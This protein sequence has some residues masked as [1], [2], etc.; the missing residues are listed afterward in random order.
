M[1]TYTFR[2]WYEA[3]NPRGWH[4]FRVRAAYRELGWKYFGFKPWQMLKSSGFIPE[5]WY[6]LKCRLWKKYN[7]VKVRSLPPTWVDR[8]QLLLHAAFEILR[9]VVENEN[10]LDQT[11]YFIPI[12]ES[13]P[14]GC[15]NRNGWQAVAQLYD[16]WINRRP[17]RLA[18]EESALEHWYGTHVSDLSDERLPRLQLFRE[19]EEAGDREDE[20]ML[21][22][23]C[24]IRQILWT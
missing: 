10:W 17:A 1:K 9:D 22:T 4:L 23:L 5:L 21:V 11:A 8:D 24:R 14:Y 7:V 13:D 19:L 20:E 18:A 12:T 16:W 6:Y 3:H 15:D 2:D